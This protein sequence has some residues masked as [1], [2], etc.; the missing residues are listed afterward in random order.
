MP[1]I[2]R[3]VGMARSYRRKINYRFYSMFKFLI[4]DFKES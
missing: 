1:A 3:F 2:K 4:F